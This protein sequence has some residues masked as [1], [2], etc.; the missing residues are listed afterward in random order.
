MF[1]DDEPVAA[2]AK[3]FKV[4]QNAV[5]SWKKKLGYDGAEDDEQRSP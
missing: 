5:R 4:S 1:E 3:R 2:I